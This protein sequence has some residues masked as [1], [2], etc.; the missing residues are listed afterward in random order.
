MECLKVESRVDE[1]RFRKLVYQLISYLKYIFLS[2]Q[3]PHVNSCFLV[4]LLACNCDIVHS[5]VNGICYGWLQFHAFV[6]R[7]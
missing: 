4:T 1:K 6:C 2:A 7:M 3:S 5:S